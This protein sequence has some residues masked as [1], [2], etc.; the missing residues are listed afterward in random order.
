MTFTLCISGLTFFLLHAVIM[1]Y[2]K[3]IHVRLTDSVNLFVK[4]DKIGDG[5]SH[6]NV[7]NFKTSLY[8]IPGV[9][10]TLMLQLTRSKGQI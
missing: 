5:A 2:M 7:V 8:K 10:C 1:C 3:I 9:S 6:E 4:R